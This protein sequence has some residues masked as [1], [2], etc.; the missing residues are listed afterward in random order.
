MK[1]TGEQ[2]ERTIDE[3]RQS[4]TSKLVQQA[5]HLEKYGYVVVDL[6]APQYKEDILNVLA[7][8][9]EYKTPNVEKMVLGGFSALGNPSSFHNPVVR[10]MR[11]E[12]YEKLVPFFKVCIHLLDGEGW[13]LEQIIDRLMVRPRSRKPT[14]ES[15]HRDEAPL[16]KAED[17]VLGGWWNQD[18]TPQ[19]FSCVPGTHKVQ[20]GGGGFSTFSKE[21]QKAFKPQRQKVCIPAGSVLIFH[22]HIVHEVLAA[23]TVPEF[24]TRLFLGWRITQSTESLIPGIVEI[25]NKQGVVPLKSGQVPP[26]F[27][28]LHLVNWLDKIVAINDNFQ[29][30]CLIQHTV[31]SGKTKGRTETIPHRFMDSL[32][33]YGFPKYPAYSQLEVQRNIPHII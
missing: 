3:Q 23:K 20:R 1:R 5:Q 25:L 6:G 29:E 33:N 7:G 14:A 22:E 32:E 31:G 9:P 15:F 18:N 8:F 10:K 11:A 16:A 28:K 21:Q 27:A 17:I 12:A 24:S 19:Y 2:L 13:K 30:A 26:I 4:P